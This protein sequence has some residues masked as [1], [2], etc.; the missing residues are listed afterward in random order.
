MCRHL[1]L[2]V[3]VNTLPAHQTDINKQQLQQSC[4]PQPLFLA[5]KLCM[6]EQRV[7]H[8]TQHNSS[9]SVA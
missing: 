9:G 8:A 3:S 1:K 4:A 7:G 5:Q 6:Q 2:I